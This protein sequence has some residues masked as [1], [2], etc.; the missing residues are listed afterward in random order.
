[1]RVTDSAEVCRA[2]VKLPFS[3]FRHRLCD[4]EV[5]GR[6]CGYAPARMHS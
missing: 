3:Q 2:T 1:M 4:M 5:G 6:E